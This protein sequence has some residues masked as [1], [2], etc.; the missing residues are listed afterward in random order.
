MMKQF[1]DIFNYVGA[2]TK[3][4]FSKLVSFRRV[5]L[6]SEGYSTSSINW[7]LYARVLEAKQAQ[8]KNS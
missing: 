5:I 7:E 8:L 1:Q 3:I 2:S 4:N 6:E